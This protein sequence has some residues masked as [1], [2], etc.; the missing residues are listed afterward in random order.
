MIKKKIGSKNN[1]RN[2]LPNYN[3]RYNFD[4]FIV[5]DNNNFA[6]NAAKRVS[7]FSQTIFNPLFIYGET[8]LGKTH[9]IQAIAHEAKRTWKKSNIEYLSCEELLNLYIGAVQ[10]D[11]IS[12]FRNRFKKVDMVLIDDIQS[13]AAKTKT[14]KEFLYIFKVLYNS[15]KQIVLT[16]DKSPSKIEYFSTNLISYFEHRLIAEIKPPTFETRL[17]ILKNKRKSLGIKINIKILSFI[18]DKISSNV[19][20]LEEAL[21]RLSAYSSITGR[22]I[23]M[24]RA[25]Y[26]LYPF[27]KQEE[28]TNTS[29]DLIQ[30]K[31]AEYYDLNV[32][33]LTLSNSNKRIT[34]PQMVAIYLSKEMTYASLS[35][36]GKTFRSTSNKT[37]IKSINKIRKERANAFKIDN[38]ISEIIL[39]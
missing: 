32:N 27:I 31:V 3:P 24:H 33:D 34:Y 2:K 39:S 7:M 23:T 21:I 5:G 14:L 18:A 11:K 20:R 30:K 37:I 19:R 9:L 10:N 1:F 28:K 22:E 6:W 29:I 4:N 36:I 35:E 12:D 26:Q 15:N 17:T 13:L 38:L 16:S 25:K 8:G